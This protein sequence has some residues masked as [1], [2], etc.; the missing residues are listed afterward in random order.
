[1]ISWFWCKLSPSTLPFITKQRHATWMLAQKLQLTSLCVPYGA[2]IPAGSPGEHPIPQ[3][4]L[5]NNCPKGF[6]SK[7]RINPGTGWLSSFPSSPQRASLPKRFALVIS[8]VYALT[9][10][11][12]SLSKRKHWVGANSF[13][14]SNSLQIPVASLFLTQPLPSF[15]SSFT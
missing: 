15:P 5:E 6:M 1:M 13:F 11:A 12:K 9:F 2:S 14:L 7:L 10:S 3:V 4:W 8:F